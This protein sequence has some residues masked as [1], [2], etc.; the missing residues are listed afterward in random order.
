MAQAAGGPSSES[1]TQERLLLSIAHARMD[2]EYG[3]WRER[4]MKLAQINLLAAQRIVLTALI[5]EQEDGFPNSDLMNSARTAA[6][7]LD[8]MAE[9]RRGAIL[10]RD[11][12]PHMRPDSAEFARAA[13]RGAQ[14]RH[15][16]ERT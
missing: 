10:L 13:Y 3:K 2:R 11:A 1:P 8:S 6:A 16:F 7:E 4:V 5:K 15:I 9:G 12:V 14:I